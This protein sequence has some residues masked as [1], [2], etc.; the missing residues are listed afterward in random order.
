MDFAAAGL[1]DGLD[2]QEREARVKLLERLLNDGCGEEELKAAVAED[3]LALVPVERVL[4]GRYTASEVAERA[5]VPES[6]VIRIRRLLGLPEPGP[7][8]RAFGDEEV[9]AAQATRLFLDE[10]FSEESIVTITR[11]LGEAM[12]RLAATITAG[13]AA[14]FLEAGD[15][16]EDIASRFAAL[17]ERLIPTLDPV[18]LG[19]FKQHLRENVR[20]AVLSR[21]EREAGQVAVEQDAAVCFVDLVGFTTLGSEIEAEELGGVVGTF[22]ELAA[23]VAEPPVRLVKTI[24]DAAML[25]N[26]DSGPLVD[27]ALSLVEAVRDADLPAARAGVAYG[28]TTSRAGDFYGHSVNLA[29]RVTGI[30]R[31]GSVLCTKEVR[32]AT[33]D[34]FDW[35]FAGRHRLKG[36][37]DSVPLYRARPLSEA[38]VQD[39]PKR[40]TADRRRRRAAN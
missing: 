16:E 21:A 27:A 28:T 8:E 19:A 31:P 29:S 9:A 11:V 2:G 5:G 35:S 23:D 37:G 36:I 26:R 30:A 14:T 20:R 15:T 22:A 1:L 3:R 34:A 7:E 10:G 40:R 32:D 39:G 13:F 6:L 33:R 4:G 12:A 38:P 18:L 17:A 25:I 24:G